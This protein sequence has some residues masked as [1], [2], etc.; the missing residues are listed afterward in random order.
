M[1]DQ[2][3]SQEVIT[4]FCV[5]PLVRRYRLRKSLTSMSLI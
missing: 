3:D 1:I 4:I 5:D 2:F